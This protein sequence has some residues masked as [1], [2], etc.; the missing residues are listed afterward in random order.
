MGFQIAGLALDSFRPLFGLSD[1]ELARHGARR[2]VADSKPGF[3][4]RVTLEDAEP[5]ETLILLPFQ[6]QPAESPYRASGPIFVRETARESYRGRDHIPAQLRTRLLS[7]RAYDE[8]GLMVSADVV[9]G[10]ELESLIERFFG[11]PQVAYL[12]AHYARQGCFACRI[13]RT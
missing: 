13:D 9:Q 11:D 6:H 8:A 1:A 12:H 10:T 7:V 2:Y 3:P 4:C 5:G